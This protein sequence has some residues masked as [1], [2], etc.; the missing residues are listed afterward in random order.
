M[1]VRVGTHAKVPHPKRWCGAP[2]VQVL[3]PVVFIVLVA[4]VEAAVST[5][6]AA[7]VH[8]SPFLSMV[9]GGDGDIP[10]CNVF[11]TSQGRYGLGNII[12]QA[13][14]NSIVYAPSG[15]AEVNTIMVELAR[16]RGFS[17]RTAGSPSVAATED[18]VGFTTEADLRTHLGEFE[19]RSGFAVVFNETTPGSSTLP[20]D[21]VY[22]AR[23]AWREARGQ[24]YMCLAGLAPWRDWASTGTQV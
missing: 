1:R 15:N 13:W 24:V 9:D 12:P 23:G 2:V 8:P 17:I 22:V 16:R 19:G 18:V 21:V 11:D 7:T 5:S 3:S 10:S 4:I 20:E 14:C 6:T